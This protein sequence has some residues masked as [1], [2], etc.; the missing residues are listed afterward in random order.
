MAQL[1][2]R[3]LVRKTDFPLLP[4]SPF[5]AP[6]RH[7]RLRGLCWALCFEGLARGDLT[8]TAQAGKQ[9]L[10]IEAAGKASALH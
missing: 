7:S 4:S 5:P 3:H 6:R 10:S 2:Q 1:T 8:L 9:A